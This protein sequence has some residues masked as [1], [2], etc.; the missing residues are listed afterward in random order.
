VGDAA[1]EKLIAEVAHKLDQPLVV[2]GSLARRGLGGAVV[3]NT[4]E[5]ILDELDTDVITIIRPRS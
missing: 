4:A 5:R 1:P 2:I 3:G